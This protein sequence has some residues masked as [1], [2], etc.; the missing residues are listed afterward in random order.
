MIFRR[1]FDWMVALLMFASSFYVLSI[2]HLESWQVNYWYYQYWLYLMKVEGRNEGQDTWSSWFEWMLKVIKMHKHNQLPAVG[3][4]FLVLQFSSGL[5]CFALG[6]YATL[7][8]LGFPLEQ[9]FQDLVTSQNKNLDSLAP[10]VALEEKSLPADISIIEESQ[11]NKTSIDWIYFTS[12][13]LLSYAT[14]GLIGAALRQV[15]L[16]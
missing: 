2:R 7:T 16:G 6:L 15:L 11:K 3:Y 8:L 12:L 13:I 14:G 9:W 4:P 1:L 5:L 10:P